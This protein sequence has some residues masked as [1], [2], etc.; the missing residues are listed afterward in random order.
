M[1]I[2]DWSSDVCSSDLAQWRD[3]LLT[4]R[5]PDPDRSLAAPLQHRPA[6]QRARISATGARGRPIAS[7]ALRFRFAPPTDNTGDGGVNALTNNPD[8]AVG[9]GHSLLPHG[10]VAVFF[11]KDIRRGILF[12][13]Q[14][15]AVYLFNR[16]V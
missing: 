8:H 1:R 4:N 13:S 10:A 5:G 7:V 15:L 9:A 6:A 11:L 3:L 2:S 16:R 12:T 14:A